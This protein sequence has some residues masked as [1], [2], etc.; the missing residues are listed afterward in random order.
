MVTDIHRAA[1]ERHTP[2]FHARAPRPAGPAS[3]QGTPARR[4]LA[5]ALTA[6]AASGALLASTLGAAG[7]ATAAPV[8]VEPGSAA[9]QTSAECM[10]AL[11][12]GTQTTTSAATLDEWLHCMG[13]TD[14]SAGA[15]PTITRGEAADIAYAAVGFPEHSGGAA[16]DDVA[17][18]HQF[19]DSVTWL[20]STG[21]VR[22]YADGQFKADRDISRDEL[23]TLLVGASLATGQGTQPAAAASTAPADTTSMPADAYADQT[24]ALLASFGCQDAS[25]EIVDSFEN[26]HATGMTTMV[27]GEPATVQIRDALGEVVLRH[28]AAHE[29]MHVL[30]HEAFDYDPTLAQSTLAQWYPEDYTSA[31]GPV[32]VYEQN[33]ECALR[34]LGFDRHQSGYDVACD[35]AGLAAGRAI[36]AGQDPNEVAAG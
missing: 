17:A 33:A 11:F 20:G 23:A 19:Y 29:C 34:G 2:A 15:A 35:E 14:G 8:S 36:A 28:T 12:P 30:Q 4:R 32:S 6:V 21:V 24:A 31:Y 5:T 10:A 13:L 18:G 25:L 3:G 16:F 9:A 7:A 26:A 27:A 1:S 22:G